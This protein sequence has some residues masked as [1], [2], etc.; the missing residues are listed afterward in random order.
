MD[1]KQFTRALSELKDLALLQGGFVS[2]IQI[3]ECLPEL[4]EEQ[5]T[6]LYDYLKQSGIGINEP[7]EYHG[8]D[9]ADYGKADSEEADPGEAEAGGHLQMYLDELN[10]SDHVD[11]TMKTL[12]LREALRG[13]KLSK[14]KLIH[15]Y[16]PSV[17][18]IAKLYVGQGADMADLIG[19]GNV[20]LTVAVDQLECVD[21]PE[22]ADALIARMIMNAMEEFVGLENDEEQLMEQI[23]TDTSKVLEQARQ[24]AEELLRKVTVEELA[25]E[26]GI[27]EE[28]IL[29]AAK[30]AKECADYIEL[31][32]GSGQ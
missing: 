15:A 7:I 21:T 24:M 2:E 3:E 27:P 6:L 13:D 23:L 32:K 18:D 14:E 4:K 29:T 9:A 31:P 16:L 22:D 5:K 19:E 10:E 1:E 30:M 20:A 25:K 12:L 17:V 28:E 26:S 11:E 8:T